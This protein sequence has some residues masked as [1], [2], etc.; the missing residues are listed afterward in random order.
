[1]TAATYDQTAPDLRRVNRAVV[2]TYVTFG[3]AGFA[4]ASWASRIPQVRDRLHLESSELG[5]V[6][7]AV[8][9]GS[10]L[11]LPLAGPMIAR[12]GARR[13]VIVTAA[14]LGVALLTV[15]FGYRIGVAPVVVGLFL[16]GLAAGAWDVAI[17][18]H[19]AFVEQQLGRS[20][21][22]RFHAGFSLG[23]VAGAL[24]GAAMVAGGVSVT[25]HLVL[26]ALVVSPSAIVAATRFLPEHDYDHS[27]VMTNDT[28]SVAAGT[29]NPQVARRGAFEA[30]REP[31]TLL[32]GVFVL[33][34][35][36]AEG[37]ANDWIAVAVIDDHHASE[38]VGTLGFAVFL[39]SMTVGRWFG[40]AL[41]DRYGRVAVVRTIAVVGIAGTMLFVLA[42][43]TWL[44]IV[45]TALWG[46]GASLGF[47]VGMSAGAD[48]PTLAASRVSV[49]SSI[50]YCAFLAGPPL[51]GFLGDQITVLRALVS[52]TVL[53]TLA[54]VIA[55]VV[56]N[57]L[58]NDDHT[59]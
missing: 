29:S 23:T 34:F 20:I 26:A 48:E 56:Q 33:A 52:V 22:S 19:G 54:A 10:L 28:S 58:L 57:P 13:T 55:P 41:L 39:A 4:I 37:V 51:I 18:V 30:W 2:A 46:L 14:L 31:R 16:F 38:A 40:P 59:S 11:A 44:A 21:M 5:L 8:A 24:F 49:I 9:V 43:V 3:G 35:A 27:A 25:V 42:P 7:L 1:M 12:F 6:L 45:G 47:P 36:F 53:L 15:A 17:N 50:G 32:I